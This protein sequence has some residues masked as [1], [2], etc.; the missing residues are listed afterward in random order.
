MLSSRP[1]TLLLTFILPAAC[2][3]HHTVAYVSPPVP[4]FLYILRVY[5]NSVSSLASGKMPEAQVS[6]SEDSGY[7][8]LT[9]P[10]ALW[11]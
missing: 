3:V 11:T 9:A 6:L 2:P 10:L 8:P 7:C 5:K 4:E 1:V